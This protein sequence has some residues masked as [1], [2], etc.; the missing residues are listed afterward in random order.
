MLGGDMDSYLKLL[1]DFDNDIQS[2]LPTLTQILGQKEF[3]Q[4]EETV[5]KIK[6][7]ASTLGI[8]QIQKAATQLEQALRDRV[9]TIQ[10]LA[11]LQN[12]IL[13]FQANL[14]KLTPN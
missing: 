10:L 14:A 5:H 6:G 3:G 1:R 8:R 13:Q 4:A 7:A 12:A 9:Y 11:N 2:D